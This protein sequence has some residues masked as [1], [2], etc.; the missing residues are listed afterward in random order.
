MRRSA[1]LAQKA[2]KRR[3]LR[4]QICV[5]S[6]FCATKP[7]GA[8]C[9]NEP[10]GSFERATPVVLARVENTNPIGDLRVPAVFSQR[11]Q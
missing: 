1:R 2:K 9:K 7:S 5:D 6:R 11:T 3:F 4:T 8:V 10:N